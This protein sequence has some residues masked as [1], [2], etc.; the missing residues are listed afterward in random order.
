MDNKENDKNEIMDILLC[1]DDAYSAFAATV[2]NSVCINNVGAHRFFVITDYISDDNQN[3]LSSLVEKFSSSIEFLFIS[4]EETENFPIGKGTA[5]TYINIAAYFRL[6]MFKLL[7]D[8]VKKVLY[9][10]CDLI[11]DGDLWNLWKQEMP[12]DI[13]LFAVEDEMFSARNGV[14]RLGYEEK[15][16]YFNSGVLLLDIEKIRKR[17]NFECIIKYINNNRSRIVYHDQD[18]LNALLYG[19]V[20]FMPLKYNVMDFNYIKGRK[21]NERYAQEK[22]AIYHPVIIH[23]SGP[24]KPWFSEC[25]HPLRYKFYK[26]IDTTSYSGFIPIPKYDKF[27]SKIRNMIKNGLK[28]I[29]EFMGLKKFSYITL[30]D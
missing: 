9:L 10:D 26:Y 7:S 20:Y 25:K 21:L 24:M 5:N 28:T 22:D 23:Y 29:I 14:K 3:K 12:S 15:Y 8:D 4:K 17:Y 19:H 2:I 18:V 13:W 30:Y 16:S 1:F 27:S 6:F 11:V